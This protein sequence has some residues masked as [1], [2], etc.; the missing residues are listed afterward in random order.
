MIQTGEHHPRNATQH[1]SA[2]R[3]NI[4][5]PA[6]GTVPL[7]VDIVVS[8]GLAGAGG[9]LMQPPPPTSPFPEL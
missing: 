7:A 3:G 6:V 5:Y 1:R 4:I 9:D 8:D 2:V